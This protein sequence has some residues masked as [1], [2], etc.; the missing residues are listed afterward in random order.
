MC[1]EVP[2]QQYVYEERRSRFSRRVTV[3]LEKARLDIAHLSEVMDYQTASKER[4]EL[5]LE[6]DPIEIGF[7]VR[8]PVGLCG[9][10]CSVKRQSSMMDVQW[11]EQNPEL[12]LMS[13]LP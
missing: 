12:D 7:K 10:D 13:L 1:S 2:A 9:D 3:L 4:G 5:A 11:G 8:S 6:S